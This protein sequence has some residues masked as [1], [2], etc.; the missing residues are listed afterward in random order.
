MLQAYLKKYAKKRI[1]LMAL[2]LLV[3]LALFIGFPPSLG[4]FPNLMVYVA[5]QHAGYD[6]LNSAAS[7]ET[8]FEQYAQT[9]GYLWLVIGIILAYVTSFC[10]SFVLLICLLY[11][12]ASRGVWSLQGFWAALRAAFLLAIVYFPLSLIVFT[13]VITLGAQYISLIPYIGT[14]LGLLFVFAF[15]SVFFVPIFS[16]T[17][18]AIHTKSM[19]KGIG[20]FFTQFSYKPFWQYLVSAALC[21]LLLLL[22]M[23]WLATLSEL[24]SILSAAAV[25]LALSFFLHAI[26]QK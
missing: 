19:R 1:L 13:P 2:L 11:H 26:A 14:F 9:S 3:W 18:G 8:L 22:F 20:L 21:I 15:S 7:A 6:I 24:A 12:F 10:V 4:V 23:P 17:F 25:L 5:E 16:I